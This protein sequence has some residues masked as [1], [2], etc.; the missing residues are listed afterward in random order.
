[1]TA[2]V[3]G[4]GFIGLLI[5][6]FVNVVAWRIPRGIS[7]ITPPSA[8]PA[9]D[10]EIRFR[11][12]I[13]LI[14]WLILRGRCRECGAPISIRY[15]VVELATGALFAA[16]A[17]MLGSVWVLVAFWWFSAV[18]IALV[19]TDLDFKRIPNRILYPGTVVATMLLG[20][21]AALDGDLAQFGRALLGGAGYFL[22]LLLVALLARGGFGFGDVKLAALLG[23]FTAFRS[24]G[25]LFTGVV[26]A[27]VIGG[28]LSIGLLV[29]RRVGRKD[30]IPFGPSMVLGAYLGITAGESIAA[31]YLG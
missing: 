17:A 27:F 31:W 7:V 26:G 2:L 11:D 16:M 1:M 8:C 3:I 12:N 5:G 18:A 23:Q 20:V 28:L 14:G 29:L 4:G 9:C 30:A 19:L 24:W 6:S 25:S 10:H 21:G 15:P 22:L 13:P